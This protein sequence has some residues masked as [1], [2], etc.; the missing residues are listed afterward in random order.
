MTSTEFQIKEVLSKDCSPERKVKEIT[1]FMTW[2]RR[3][4]LI[5]IQ[6]EGTDTDKQQSEIIRHFWDRKRKR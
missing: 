3:E 1:E 2:D 5:E 6:K 4:L